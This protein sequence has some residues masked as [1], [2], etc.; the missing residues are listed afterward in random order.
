MAA[1]PEQ[2]GAGDK[3]LKEGALGFLSGVVIGV[4]STA[5][6]YSLAAVLGGIA[7][8]A[9]IGLHAPAILLISFVPMLFIATAFYYLNKA[10]PDCGTTFS[11]CTR[12]FGPWVGWMAGWAVLAADIIVMANLADIA[13]LY[14]WILVGQDAPSR[15]AVM[16]VGIIWMVAMTYIVYV[17]IEAS[18]RTQYGLLGMELATLAIFS[19]IALYKVAT[20]NIRGE[21]TP[22]LEWFNPFSMSSSALAAGV[23][24]GIFIYWGWDSTV[25]VNEESADPTEGPGKAAVVSTVVLLGIYVLVGVAAQAYHGAGFLKANS[26]DV[27]SSLGTDVL[28]SPWD[29]LLIIAVLTSASASCQTTILPATRSALSMAAK[30]AAPKTFGTI[31]PEYLTPSVATI[32]MGVISVVWY[33]GL[34]L[35]SDNVLYDAVAGLG[36]MIAFYY[37]IT[38]FACPVYFRRE[39]K[40]RPRPFLL[41]GVAPTLGG[42]VLFWALYK[43]ISDGVDPNPDDST[44]WLGHFAPSVV[45]GVGFFLLGFLLMFGMWVADKTFFRRRP[46]VAPPG[47]LEAVAPEPVADAVTL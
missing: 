24:L 36:M 6:G 41:T 8:V 20:M 16:T 5:P 30:R 45:I 34:K 17:G 26:D 39:L 12:A 9:G 28:G 33:I 29:K 2:G 19:V 43:S 31:H 38:G 46:E 18:A 7:L 25:N 1:V 3:G 47:F 13:G 10:D 11:W 44:I 42:I 40:T 27:L 22:S 23:I 37:G 21:I 32:W 14:S 15:L 4:A 35:I